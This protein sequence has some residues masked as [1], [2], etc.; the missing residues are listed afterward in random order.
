MRF[1]MVLSAQKLSCRTVHTALLVDIVDCNP[2]GVP[3]VKLRNSDKIIVGDGTQE[4]EPVY[5]I[6][7]RK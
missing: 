7:V 2:V 5:F 1:R 3:V 4:T 6:G